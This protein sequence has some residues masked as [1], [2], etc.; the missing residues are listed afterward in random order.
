MT[1]LLLEPHQDDAVLF[2]TFNALR[3]HAHVVT[4]L[5]SHVQERRGIGVTNAS[6]L[7]ENEAAVCGV[8][9][10]EWTQWPYSDAD[11]DWGAVTRA[12]EILD[13]RLEPVRVLAPAVELGGHDHH[14]QVGSIARMLFGDRLT[15]YMTY[16]RHE[17][18]STG[19]EVEYEPPWVTL[20]LRAL[21]CYRS[22]IETPA[23]G[24][25]PWF[26]GDQREWVEA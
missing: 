22:Q 11:P 4:I 3:F 25:T 2:S 23:A 26:I 7:A 13:E 15:G 8:L 20:K 14:N 18:K 24:C 9:G 19:R 5:E 17:G 16:R 6:R 12:L 21:A 10:L 1:T